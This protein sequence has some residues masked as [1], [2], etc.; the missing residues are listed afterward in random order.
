[1]CKI[2][3][4][5]ILLLLFEIYCPKGFSQYFS[6]SGPS[7]VTIPYGANS[8]P[9][10]FYFYNYNIPQQAVM[11]RLSVILDGETLAGGI[12]WPGNESYL[13]DQY[14][15]T[16]TQGSHTVQ[17]K[18]MSLGEHL[19]CADHA[20]TWQSNQANVIAI[21]TIRVENKDFAG[22]TV[23][24]DNITRNAP[25]PKT[26][27]QGTDFSIGG[28]DQYAAGYNWIWNTSGTNNSQWWRQLWQQNPAYY[29][30]DRNTSYTAQANDRNTRLLAGLKKLLA[31]VIF[32]NSFVGVGNGG[33]IKVNGIQYNSPKIASPVVELNPVASSSIYQVVNGIEY[34]FT[35]W[36]DGVTTVNRTFYPLTNTTYT[37]YYSGKPYNAYRNLRFTPVTGQPITLFW[38][39]HPNTNVTQYQIW[40]M[41]KHNGVVG[42]PVLLSTKNRGTL[43]YTDF[44]YIYTSGYTDDLVKYD[45]RAYYNIEGTYADPQWIAVYAELLPKDADSTLN[46]ENDPKELSVSCFP[47]P[48]NPVTNIR[49][50]VPIDG[51]LQ[52]TVF[53]ILGEKVLDL[54]NSIVAKGTYEFSWNGSDANSTIVNS[55][56]YILS[57][58]TEFNVISQK[59]LFL[60]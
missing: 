3:I 21:F 54:N 26:A 53:N 2:K 60:K 1:M 10:T 12:C 30:Y 56:I 27:E 22:G 40:R 49:V 7:T 46:T 14:T 52:I 23:K 13:P 38:N 50:T 39:E 5:F 47:N 41:V 17:F 28:I 20:I 44:D 45:V 31:N 24:V 59:I 33:I 57:V 55:G 42:D 51:L 16:F 6:Y 29:S 32:Q 34:T 4:I 36:N 48:F 11:P 37:A 58:R 9:G 43:T 15:F 35:Q 19:P 25:F 8:A 18:L